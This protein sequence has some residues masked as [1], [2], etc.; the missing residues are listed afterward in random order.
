MER[1]LFCFGMVL[2]ILID[3]WVFVVLLLQS[4]DHELR[5][6]L[7]DLVALRAA[8]DGQPSI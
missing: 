4:A 3:G 1:D 5:R 2:L 6:H 7:A 8:G